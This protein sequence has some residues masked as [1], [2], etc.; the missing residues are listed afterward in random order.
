MAAANPG[1]VVYTIEGSAEIAEIAKENFAEAGLTNIKL[2]TDSFENILPII[3]EKKMS[4]GL[5]FIDGNHRKEPTIEYFTRISGLSDKDTVIVIDDIYHSAEMAE[6]WD[7]IKRNKR[8]SVTIDICRMG[9]VFFRDGMTRSD[10]I[11]RY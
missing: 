7:E 10:Y 3:E 1:A 4:P 11:I 8:V 9:I 2:F 6:A 5:V